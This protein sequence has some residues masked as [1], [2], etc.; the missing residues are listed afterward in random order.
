MQLME[1][2]HC[3]RSKDCKGLFQATEQEIRASVMGQAALK[4]T[5]R[6][7]WN[8]IAIRKMAGRVFRYPQK[9]LSSESRLT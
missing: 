1:K 3:L 2:S 5:L 8:E 7:Y 6:Y 9:I 4:Q